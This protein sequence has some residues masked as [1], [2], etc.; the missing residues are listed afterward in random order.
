MLRLDL[1]SSVVR[2]PPPHL[3]SV[4]LS[5]IAMCVE[6][7]GIAVMVSAREPTYNT[8]VS[9]TMVGGDSGDV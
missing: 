1:L 5:V 2:H 9:G 4:T 8:V 6:W 3:Q 7:F